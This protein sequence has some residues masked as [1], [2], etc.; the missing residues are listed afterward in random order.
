MM[1]QLEVRSGLPIDV[2]VNDFLHVFNYLGE[3]IDFCFSIKF[4][5]Y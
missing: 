2:L 1:V 4:M 3:H 5:E